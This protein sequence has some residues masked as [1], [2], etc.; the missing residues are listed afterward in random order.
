MCD[1]TVKTAVMIAAWLTA[2]TPTMLDG[3]PASSHAWEVVSRPVIVIGLKS[4]V[5]RS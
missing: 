1:Y 5:E 4:L 3:G 2:W